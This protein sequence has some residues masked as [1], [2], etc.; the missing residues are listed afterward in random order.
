[1][2]NFQRLAQEQEDTFPREVEERKVS[3]TYYTFRHIGAVVDHF[4]GR[5]FDMFVSLSGGNAGT[6]SPP[7]MGDEHF[8][9]HPPMRH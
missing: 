9:D 2:N 3:T 4:F 5:A 1:M 8:D 7:N 6:K